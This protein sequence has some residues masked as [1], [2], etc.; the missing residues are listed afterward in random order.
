MKKLLFGIVVLGSL[1]SY[2]CIDLGSEKSVCAG[3]TVY[4]NYYSQGATVE[5]V[6]R[7]AN[8]VTVAS[9]ISGNSNS[10]SANQLYLATGCNNEGMCVNDEIITSSYFHGATITGVNPSN[11][12]LMVKYTFKYY[13]DY[14]QFNSIAA[15]Q[16]YNKKGCLDDVCVGDI[17]R[18]NYHRSGAKVV[19]V[20]LIQRRVM[21]EDEKSKNVSNIDFKSVMVN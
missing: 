5:I 3:D 2:A 17:V 1:S 8:R 18:T 9:N 6:N 12:R 20:N 21:L 13:D 16:V 4:T 19:G 14:F 11:N 7:E 10:I 15:S